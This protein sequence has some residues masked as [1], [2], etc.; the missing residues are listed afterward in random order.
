MKAAEQNILYM[1]LSHYT[2]FLIHNIN[3]TQQLFHYV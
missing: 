1:I 3:Y 2:Q